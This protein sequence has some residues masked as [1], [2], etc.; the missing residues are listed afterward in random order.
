MATPG[1]TISPEY[2]AHNER[3]MRAFDQLPREL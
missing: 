3:A 2:V 1:K